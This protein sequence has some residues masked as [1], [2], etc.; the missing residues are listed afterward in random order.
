MKGVHRVNI[1][2]YADDLVLFAP[3]AAGLKILIERMVFNH[4]LLTNVAE[5]KL[6][7]FKHVRRVLGAKISF[8]YKGEPIEIVDEYKYLGITIQS[9]L[10][11]KN[12]YK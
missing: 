12:R 9:N 5:T 11:E 1:Q 3:T 8:E 2:G 10:I 4:E 7:V 6:V